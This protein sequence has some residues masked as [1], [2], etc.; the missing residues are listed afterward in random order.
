M[1][2]QHHLLLAV[3]ASPLVLSSGLTREKVHFAPAE[4]ASV[5]KDFSLT[6]KFELDDMQVL[7]NGAENEMMPKMEMTMG[8]EQAVKVIDQYVKVAEGKPGEL[9]RRYDDIGQDMKVDVS[10]E[11]MGQ[12]QDQSM[13]GTGTSKLEGKTVA[14]RWDESAEEYT[15]AFEEG[16]EGDSALLE[17][18]Q[19]DMDL[20]MLLPS[21]DVS[22]GDEWD[23]PLTSLVD[24]FSPGGDLKMDIE[25]S[26]ED[27]GMGMGGPGDPQLMSNMREMFGE[28]VK[29]TATAK[30]TGMRDVD[31]QSCGVIEIKID[32]ESAN[33]LKDKVED[34]MGD[35]LPEGMSA[36]IDSFDVTFT[37]EGGGELLWDLRGGHAKGLDLKG[38]VSLQ[39]DMAMAMNVGQEMNIEMSMDMSGTIEQKV[40]TE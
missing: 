22:E 17:D 7:M 29:G 2:H 37:Y 5:T 40:T 14:F 4:G 39:M 15:K 18:L 3:L 24:L 30:Y 31:G 16:S 11:M 20:R 33:D 35:K 32:I 21:E 6:G 26:G 27:P 13:T 36:S 8:W 10:M 25:M 1:K 9:Q 12:S 38:D 23:I 19:E 28:S 34:M